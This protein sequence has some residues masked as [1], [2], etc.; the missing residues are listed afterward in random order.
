MNRLKQKAKIKEPVRLRAKSLANGNQSLYLDTYRKGKRA[1]EFLRL[2]LIPEK[3]AEDK[4]VNDATMKA[5]MAIKA[6]RI[7]AFVNGN[8]GIKNK[9]N[10]QSLKEW[11]SYIIKEKEGHKS[12]SCITLMNRL[13]RHLDKF[14]PST[15]LTDVDREFC[16][17]FADYL[18]SAKA[19]N[20]KKQLLQT[21]QFELL[22]ALSIVLNE[23]V[24][25][26]QIPSNPMRLLN[27]SERIKRPE[28]TREYLTIEEVKAIIEIATYNIAAGDD[29]A[30]FLFCCFSGLR[31]SDVSSLKWGN[32]IETCCGKIIT[33]KMKKTCRLVEVP[34][35]DTA[36]SFLPAQGNPHE[37]VFSMPLYG[38]TARKLK[39]I[40]KAAGIKKK[41]HS[42]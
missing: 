31:Y 28:S 14:E 23:A 3:T 25:A 20:S 36:S 11:I 33:M 26:E 16:I 18:R 22:N 15:L 8:A 4:A 30:A 12:K 32:I 40:A 17:G 38:V 5:A 24:R 35:S 39:K 34:V 6:K 21:T 1:Y 42:I 7:I 19:L 27:A 10:Q 13:I 2:Y 37:N 29:V 9:E 41:L